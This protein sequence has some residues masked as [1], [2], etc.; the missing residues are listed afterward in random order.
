MTGKEIVQSF[1]EGLAQKSD[2]WKEHLSENV[3]FSDASMKL[4]TEGKEA[5]VTA[6]DS[7]L[8]AVQDLRVKQMI[9]E[10]DNI[11][12]I[13]SYDYVSPKGEKLTQDDAE[14]WK[15]ED[16][17]VKSLVIYFDITAFRSFMAR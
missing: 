10:Q 11:C 16:G 17:K 1:Y 9:V 12:A 13:V 7:F 5:F 15:I 2:A 8:R 14:I 6:F 3:V 4:H